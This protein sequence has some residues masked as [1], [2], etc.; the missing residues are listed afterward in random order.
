MS[1][2]QKNIT[3]LIFYLLLIHSSVTLLGQSQKNKQKKQTLQE[4]IEFI[5]SNSDYI[6]N[7]DPALLSGYTCA[8][9]IDPKPIDKNLKEIFSDS[10]FEYDIEDQMILIYK[11]PPQSYRICGTL[12]DA[13]TQEPLIAANIAA[14][15]T[16][17]GTTSDLLG[18]F[19]FDYTGNKNQKFE[20][21]YLGYL[22]IR[23]S[24]QDIDGKDCLELGM[25]INKDLFGGEIIIHDY[26][27]DGISMGEEYTALHLDYNQLSKNHST[28]EHDIF[29]TA[30]LLPGINSIDDSATNLQIRGSNPGQNLVLWEGV[31][32]YNAGH[33]FGMVSAINPF[34]VEEVSIYK[35]AHD[36][37]YDNRVGG[38]LD[39]SL[40][41]ELT[42]GFHGSVGTT[43]T[44]F[45]SNLSI[46]IVKDKVSIEIAGRQSINEIFNSPTLQSYTDKVFQFSIIDEQKN[47]PDLDPLKAEQT[48]TYHD[49]NAKILY[50]PSDKFMING[51]FYRN[52]QDFNYSFSYEA[53]TLIAE[54][55]INL[56]TEI[57]SLGTA[58]DV[59]K[60]WSSSL[61]F[62]QSSYVNNYEKRETENEIIIA[63]NDQLNQITEQ[64]VTFSNKLNLGPKF[65]MNLGYEYNTKEVKMDL[66]NDVDFDPEFI[67]FEFER[68]S[69]H[70][71]FQSFN[72]TIKHLQ[73]DGGNRS[74]YYQEL[75]KWFHSPRINLQY[76]LNP[77]LK[78][79]ADAGVY[80]QFISQL[81]N[82][83]TNQIKV[84]NPLW[85]LNASESSLSQKA[86]KMSLG[87]VYQ[88]NKW[89]VDLDFYFN[90]T[91]N[92]TNVVPQ[93]GIITDINGF[94]TGTFS[95]KGMDFLLKK[96]WS[97][98]LSTWLNYSLGF[99]DYD[100]PDFFEPT[101]VAP[102][103]IRHNLSYVTSYKYKAFQLSLNAN[104]H[105]G[106]PYTQGVLTPNEDDPDALPPFQ[107]FLTYESYNEERLK[108][109]LRID[110]SAAYR[111]NLTRREKV[112]M[113]IS[114][115]VINVL[116]RTNH[117]A[118]EYF[119]D[120]NET[121][122][123]YKLS[124]I[125]KSLLGRTPLLLLRFYW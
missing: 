116:N 32:L 76:D 121:T 85:I 102:N 10:P 104:Y 38:I 15:N 41:D 106:L 21:S 80:H 79:K 100:F 125:Q 30:Q 78:L 81:T 54:D 29:K 55:K 22:P 122:N 68:A 27:L 75:D 99:A 115:S 65:Q 91:S 33:V 124:F 113:E 13:L 40:G 92:I 84:D 64:S 109:Y 107:Y 16:A 101:F 95:V 59:T 105:S 108:P 3:Y 20:I 111:F 67:P 119:I 17:I 103:D 56:I 87:L 58:Y 5:E 8:R 96:R 47:S 70:N 88:K 34:S 43:L 61:D 31:P 42:R 26:L 86:N 60:K 36:P 2:Q 24:V 18:Y 46:P 69:F 66:G 50:R 117:V 51:G 35:G 14:L 49:W 71:L 23:F 53:D 9:K 83:G 93:L 7:Y 25:N 6:F 1:K 74:S 112:R 62:Y 19:E 39:I 77:N 4:A 98:K 90:R 12:V 89:L 48:L 28:V 118:R 123:V 37:K 52:A 110:L 94:S 97:K 82:V 114:C 57:V 11:P 63:E 73:I 120:Y 45:H 72:Y 44:E